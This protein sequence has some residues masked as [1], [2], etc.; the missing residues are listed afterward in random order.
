MP[1]RPEGEYI[2]TVGVSQANATSWID[3]I[4]GG[5]AVEATL[6]IDSDLYNIT[7]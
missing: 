5:A 1:P 4:T 6:N 7:M 2:P 3:T